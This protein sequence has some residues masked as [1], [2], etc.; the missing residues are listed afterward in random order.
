MIALTNKEKKWSTCFFLPLY[1]VLARYLLSFIFSFVILFFNLRLDE[2]MIDPW[3]NVFYD[4]LLAVI[5]IVIF[6]EFLA[7][8]FKVTKG[9]RIKL[10][11]WSLTIGFLILYA[12]NIISGIIVSLFSSES[13]TN[14]TNIIEM[15]A[16]APWQMI[17]SSVVFAP[18]LEELVFRVGIFACLYEKNRTWAYLISSL[19]FGM[20]HIF[21]GLVAGDL[22]QLLFLM[23]Y[24][25]L[26]AVFCY[27]YEKKG[28]VM[29]P[30][31]VHAANN[32]VS[33]ALIM[34]F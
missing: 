5:G 14:Q 3:F 24:S 18:I 32:F 21:Q 19:A 10:L 20:I 28:S 4:G 16:I 13:S 8:D 23:P 33:M 7:K 30:I 26:G 34:F 11:L 22:M 9:K 2:A 25:L 12:T 27:L 15:A 1:F 31:L 6:R 29:V 17:V